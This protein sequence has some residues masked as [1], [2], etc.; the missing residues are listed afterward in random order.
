MISS[1]FGFRREKELRVGCVCVVGMVGG[2][3][4]G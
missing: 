1:D 2:D 3:D 4:G